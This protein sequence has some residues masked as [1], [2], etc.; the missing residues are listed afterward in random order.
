MLGSTSES[1]RIPAGSTLSVHAALCKSFIH[2][3]FPPVWMSYFLSAHMWLFIKDCS[4]LKTNMFPFSRL[5]CKLKPTLCILAAAV[6]FCMGSNLALFQCSLCLP[7]P[8]RVF[9]DLFSP[10]SWVLWPHW[11][12]SATDCDQLEPIKRWCLKTLGTSPRTK[13]TKLPSFLFCLE[14]IFNF[15]EFI[16][17]FHKMDGLFWF[18]T[19]LIR[20]FRAVWACKAL[21]KVGLLKTNSRVQKQPCITTT[22]GA[23]LLELSSFSTSENP[24]R[25]HCH[26]IFF[27]L[28][29]RSP[30]C[31]HLCMPL[32]RYH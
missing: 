2:T 22:Q 31:F 5:A 29:R 12:L 7:S 15:I 13:H 28:L 21:F 4:S 27:L 25:N 23:T 10:T 11:W 1:L 3:P 6:A 19:V 16:S 18:F 20:C 9:I 26:F 14:E 8:V 24:T 30:F 32:N 17:T